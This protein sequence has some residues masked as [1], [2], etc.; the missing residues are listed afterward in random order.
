MATVLSL[1]QK[2][3]GTNVL[4]LSGETISVWLRGATKSFRQLAQDGGDTSI[5]D[6]HFESK[7]SLKAATIIAE[8]LTAHGM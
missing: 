6:D 2:Y 5:C 3:Y 4:L 1:E 7:E 8:A